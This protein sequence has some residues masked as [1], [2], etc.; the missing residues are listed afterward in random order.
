MALRLF[1]GGV[2][3]LRP[4]DLI[5][6]GHERNH[7]DGCPWCEARARGEAHE[8][9]DGPSQRTDRVYA[10]PNRLYAKHYASLF[11]RG[12]LYRVE[13]VGEV[14]RSTEDTIETWCAPALRVIA[15][16]DRAV[17]LTRSERRR[18]LREWGDADRAAGVTAH[19]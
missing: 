5:R 13:P 12:D 18:L 9:M 14:D 4:G 17:L 1:H 8:G 19:G 15:A 3:G 16:V 10:T 11:G 6:P 2:P 7:H